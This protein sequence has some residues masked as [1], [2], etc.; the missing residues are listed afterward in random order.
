MN[1]KLETI[2]QIIEPIIKNCGCELIEVQYAKD[3]DEMTLTVF[4]NKENGV[5]I[6]DCENVHNAIDAMI[7]SIDISNGE[8]YN[9]SVSS[10]GLTRQLKNKKEFMY[11]LNQELEIK[12]FKPINNKKEFI[13]KLIKV[14]DDSIVLLVNNEELELSMKDIASAKLK[15]DF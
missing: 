12:L 11:R 8:P 14:F 2:E 10:F 15:I 13:G 6:D 5:S 4:I 1:N 3:G 7:D 9:L